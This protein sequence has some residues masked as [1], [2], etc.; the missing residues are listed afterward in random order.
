MSALDEMRTATF[1]L[2]DVLSRLQ[3]VSII[4]RSKLLE[5]CHKIESMPH[6]PNTFPTEGTEPEPNS[7]DKLTRWI[8]HIQ[9]CACAPDTHPN[10][11]LRTVRTACEYALNGAPPPNA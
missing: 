6:W 11:T 1:L 3:V 8:E 2:T 4:D 7:A 5:V 10:N 9:I